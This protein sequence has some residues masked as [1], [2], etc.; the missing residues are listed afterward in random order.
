MQRPRVTE[1]ALQ[2]LGHGD[3]LVGAIAGDGDDAT[4][5]LGDGALL[6]D[7]EE[8]GLGG[9]GEVGTSTELD[10]VV[11]PLGVLEVRAGAWW[12]LGVGE[13]VGD[14]HTDGDDTDHVG[15][16][17]CGVRWVEREVVV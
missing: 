2:L 16:V 6:D 13:E 7:G 14:G 17:L 3:A 1:L 12:D 15:V 9:I 5:A 8:L 4:N 11:E 10:G